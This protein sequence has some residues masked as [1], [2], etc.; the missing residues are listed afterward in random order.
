[1]NF[2]E[3]AVP[4]VGTL[5]EETYE[6]IKADMETAYEMLMERLEIPDSVLEDK[7]GWCDVKDYVIY[8]TIYAKLHSRDIVLTDTGF[9][10]VS[11]DTIAPASPVRVNALKEELEYRRDFSLEHLIRM[12][13]A[14]HEWHE[15][16]G[17]KTIES[18]IW[19]PNQVQNYCSGCAEIGKG[20]KVTFNTVALLAPKIM[21]AQQTLERRWGAKLMEVMLQQT[22]GKVFEELGVVYRS[23]QE[24]M[25]R[26][27]SAAV[28]DLLPYAEN[29]LDTIGGYIEGNINCFPEYKDSPEYEA[30][31]YESKGN[32]PEGKVFF[33]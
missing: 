23:L 12:C 29:M 14:T 6:Y 11:N 20:K 24:Y 18:L 3:G 5:S 2:F 8:A 7:K 21:A 15:S 19:S 10:V 26:Y 28:C 22:R 1:M 25:I 16:A 32:T 4:F 27:I 9:G 31:H 13:I 17:A 30:N 33:L